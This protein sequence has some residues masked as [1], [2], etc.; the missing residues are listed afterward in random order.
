MSPNPRTRSNSRTPLR[1]CCWWLVV[2][3]LT[4]FACEAAG[5]DEDLVRDEDLVSVEDEEES[6][7]VLEEDIFVPTKE[8]KVVKDGQHIP[9]G[10]HV[11]MDFQ[12]GVKEAKLLEPD[13]EKEEEEE[14]DMGR[15]KSSIH[16]NTRPYGESDR[17]GVVNK[18]TKVFSVEEVADM[19]KD[20][21]NDTVDLA[22]LP[23]LASSKTEESGLQPVGEDGGGTEGEATKQ[24]R[25]HSSSSSSSRELPVTL[26]R[27][28]EAMLE[29]SAVLAN[30]SSTVS[31]LC[32]AL[33]ELEFYVHQIQ[34]AR[35]LNGIGGLVLVVR[36]LNHTHPDVKSWASRVI[37]SAS[38]R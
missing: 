4:T 21:N 19:L 10:L 23:Q 11:R 1:L 7:G 30:S 26:P 12:T 25:S 14:E 24:S 34:N 13:E 15:V 2:A 35:D 17:R 8:W 22:H 5:E 38:Q 29:L 33:E 20:L 16:E 37:G 28:V 3:S 27:D 18:R 31:S 9:P 32:Q 36:L 6:Q